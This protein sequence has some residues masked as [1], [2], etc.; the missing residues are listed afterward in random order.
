MNSDGRGGSGDG[1]DKPSEDHNGIMEYKGVEE[2]MG[3]R[4]REK[5]T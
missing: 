4:S 2:K 5:L 3:L 1:L